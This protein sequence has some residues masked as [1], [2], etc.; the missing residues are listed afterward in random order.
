MAI[1][2]LS[3]YKDALKEIGGRSLSSLTEDRKSRRALDDAW[4]NGELINSCL[5]VAQWAFATRTARLDYDPDIS[6]DFGFAYAFEKPDDYVQTVAVATDEYFQCPLTDFSDEAGYWFA[7]VEELYVKYISDD[8]SYGNDMTKW[9]PSFKDFVVKS[10]AASAC[11]QLTHSTSREEKLENKVERARIK[12][13]GK[14]A[15]KKPASFMPMGRFQQARVGGGLRR[16]D[17]AGWY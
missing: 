8:A 11:Y 17:R 15:I 1:T 7:D 3:L 16:Y 9:P 4:D 13:I 12:A 14:D 5:E 6:P 2:Q 10:L